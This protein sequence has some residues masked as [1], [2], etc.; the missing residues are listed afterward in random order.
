MRGR[1]QQVWLLLSNLTPTLPLHSSVPAFPEEDQLG[2]EREEE[3]RT[4]TTTTGMT[5]TWYSYSYF[6]SN[7]LYSYF[8]YFRAEEYSSSP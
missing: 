1:L 3:G 2:D 8:Y 4:T 6:T 5:S 7:Y